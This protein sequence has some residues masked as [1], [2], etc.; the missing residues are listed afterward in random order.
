MQRNKS[1][2][3]YSSFHKAEAKLSDPTKSQLVI[4][5]KHTDHVSHFT[6]ETVKRDKDSSMISGFEGKSI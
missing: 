3:L 1:K 6:Y 5:S 4:K 2:K